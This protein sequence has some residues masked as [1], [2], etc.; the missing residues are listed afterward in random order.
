MHREEK[1][2]RGTARKGLGIGLEQNAKAVSGAISHEP[3]KPRGSSLASW[4][5]V[6]P[7]A[8]SS[9]LPGNGDSVHRP[10]AEVEPGLQAADRDA[11]AYRRGGA[12]QHQLAG[13]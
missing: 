7:G 11:G 13:V 12:T 3:T 9:G 8:G 10:G 1:I 5:G 4:S 2:L 6:L